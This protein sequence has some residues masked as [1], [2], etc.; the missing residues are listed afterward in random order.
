MVA[1]LMR[2]EKLEEDHVKFLCD[3]AREILATESNV[4]GVSRVEQSLDC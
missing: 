2:G 3:K 1:Q 4:Q